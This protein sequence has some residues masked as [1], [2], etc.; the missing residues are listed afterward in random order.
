MK[1]VFVAS[2]E[3]N[4]STELLDAAGLSPLP[5]SSSDSKIAALSMPRLVN[6]CGI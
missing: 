3:G 6:M 5:G 1:C 2:A 4:T